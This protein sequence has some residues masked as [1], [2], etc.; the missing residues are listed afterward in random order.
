MGNSSSA[1][2]DLNLFSKGGVFTSEQLDEY[3][4]CTFFTKKD[5]L[6]LYKRFYALNP[7][8]VP[9]NMQGNRASI[10]TLSY[11]EVEKMP[12]LKVNT[13]V[14]KPLKELNFQN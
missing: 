8:K 2:G 4:D 9:T 13:G 7:A 3:Q 12:E 6:R 14:K 1:I 10:V 11:E 5:I